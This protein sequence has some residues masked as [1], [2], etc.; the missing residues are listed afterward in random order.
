VAGAEAVLADCG[1]ARTQRWA[2]ED[3]GRLRSLA[4]PSLCLDSRLGYSVVLAPCPDGSA[5]RAGDVRYDF[6]PQGGLVPRRDQDLALAPAAPGAAP[7]QGTA[8][9]LK[10]RAKGGA[11]QRWQADSEGTPRTQSV[12]W[13][14]EGTP[15]DR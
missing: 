6:T 4:G 9:V 14:A 11:E 13:G 2:Y 1:S 3:D 12:N 15:G 8:L 10:P 5:P 7:G